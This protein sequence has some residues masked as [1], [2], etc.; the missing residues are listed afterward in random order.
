[1]PRFEREALLA[2]VLLVVT[3][4]VGVAGGVVLERWVLRERRP[5]M[6]ARGPGMGAMPRRDPADLRLQF[7][8]QLAQELDLDSGQRRT[9]DSLIRLQQQEA[10]AAMRALRP[11]LDSINAH[12]EQKIGALLTPEQRQRWEELRARRIRQRR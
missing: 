12:T 5:P 3:L 11:R 10:R 4:L 2:A 6:V 7:T 9:A 1:M 8:R